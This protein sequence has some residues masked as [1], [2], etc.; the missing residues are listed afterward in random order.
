VAQLLVPWL[1]SVQLAAVV[2]L[3]VAS[4]QLVAQLVVSWPLAVQLAAVVVLLVTLM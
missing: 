2:V 1:L 4:V 3:L